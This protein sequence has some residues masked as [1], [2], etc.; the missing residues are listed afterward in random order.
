MID[1]PPMLP[2]WTNAGKDRAAKFSKPRLSLF[3]KLSK[4]KKHD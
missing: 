1:E 2:A 4:R 3:R